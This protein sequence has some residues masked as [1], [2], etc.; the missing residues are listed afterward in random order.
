MVGQLYLYHFDQ[1]VF[2]NELLTFKTVKNNHREALA[3][4]KNLEGFTEK[5]IIEANRSEWHHKDK[6][7]PLN[8]TYDGSLLTF[9]EYLRLNK[10]ESIDL[11][12]I[13]P[14]SRN[15]ELVAVSNNRYLLHFEFVSGSNPVGLCGAGLEVI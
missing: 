4:Y 13:A 7:L 9:K 12:N 15:Y 1:P 10:S 8:M 11:H 14:T 5:F 3:Y 6:V 2:S